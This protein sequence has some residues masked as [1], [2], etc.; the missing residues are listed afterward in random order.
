[1]FQRTVVVIGILTLTLLTGC[2]V[3]N[4]SGNVITDERSIDGFEA[5]HL[6]ID[7]DVTIQQGERTFLTIRGEDNIIESIETEIR[8]NR[9]T[10][11][12][13]DRGLMTIL[14]NTKPIEI[15]ISTPS[16]EEID[17][18]G[19][20][21]VV[22]EAL[23]SDDMEITISGSGDVELEQL[24]SGKVDV[25]IS[26]SGNFEVNGLSA[27]SIEVGISGSGDV[28]AKGRANEAELNVSGSGAIEAGSMALNTADVRVSGSGEI[29]TWVK[30]TLD[31]QVSGSGDV[32]YYGDP[33]VD[34]DV[35]GSGD[36]VSL[37]AKE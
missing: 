29:T 11:K 28:Q 3:V 4:G 22:S 14:R 33:Q 23:T 25:Q 30:E 35:S 16:L 6:A 31:V 5:L 18:S 1:M 32:S 10:I 8:R 15:T 27:D 34:D 7:A 36:V 26:G 2:S 20:G 24:E 37:G 21:N 17:V 9:L 13:Q 19:S 12:S